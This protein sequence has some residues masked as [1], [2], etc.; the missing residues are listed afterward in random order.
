MAARPTAVPLA[1]TR[2]AVATA[3]L[4]LSGSRPNHR[5]ARVSAP[6]TAKANTGRTTVDTRSQVANGCPVRPIAP[7]APC[8]DTSQYPSAYAST[9]AST[10]TVIHGTVRGPRTVPSRAAVRLY[11]MAV[12][13]LY[14]ID[15]A[16]I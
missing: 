3:V 8:R 6:S 7:T 2:S 5:S 10:T 9:T 14:T 12:M 16:N 1:T 15:Q 11:E 13:V 4:V